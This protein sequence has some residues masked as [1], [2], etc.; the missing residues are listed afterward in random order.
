MTEQQIA[1]G[2]QYLAMGNVYKF[3]IS[4]RHVYYM[5]YYMS[6]HSVHYVL[7]VSKHVIHEVNV[8][9]MFHYMSLY[10]V[11]YVLHVIQTTCNNIK[12][13]ICLHVSIHIK[14]CL[15]T[16]KDFFYMQYDIVLHSI[17][18]NNTCKYINYIFTGGG[19]PSWPRTSDNKPLIQT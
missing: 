10:E 17:T 11:H 12:Y 3:M 15:T 13:T 4:C 7:H 18:C 19:W 9:Y 1:G 8:C 5:Q 2:K 16:K 14:L 6:L